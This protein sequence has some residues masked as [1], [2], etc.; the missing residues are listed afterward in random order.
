[1]NTGLSTDEAERRQVQLVNPSLK[2]FPYLGA[3]AISPTILAAFH[4]RISVNF[5]FQ[6]L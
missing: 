2:K 3:I 5:L 6:F 1:M 4:L